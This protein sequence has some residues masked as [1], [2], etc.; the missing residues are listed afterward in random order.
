MGDTVSGQRMTRCLFF[1]IYAIIQK[2]GIKF[3]ENKEKF[4]MYDVLIIGAGP[5]GIFSAYELME[6]K[7]DLKIA[8]F[9]VGLLILL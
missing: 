8:V 7:P 1:R 6:R 9:E 2:E 4:N 5:G 3:Q